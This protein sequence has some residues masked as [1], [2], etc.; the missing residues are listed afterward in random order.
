L[1][2]RFT[3][4]A[5]SSGAEYTVLIQKLKKRV[6][7]LQ[8]L[9]ESQEGEIKRLTKTVKVVEVEVKEDNL[10]LHAEIDSLKD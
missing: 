6:L 5:T 1:S 4:C 3:G 7:M 9:N 2:S 10:P 8:A